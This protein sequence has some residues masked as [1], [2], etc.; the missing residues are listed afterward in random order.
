MDEDTTPLEWLWREIETRLGPEETEPLREVY[1]ARLQA[2][3]K[4]KKTE[5]RRIN[6]EA[7]E[8]RG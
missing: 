5:A 6:R 1:N 7:F 3:Q 8:S 4:R 2:Y